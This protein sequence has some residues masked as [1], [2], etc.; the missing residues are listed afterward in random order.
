VA[1]RKSRSS[2]PN[3]GNLG[4]APRLPPAR[5]QDPV[6]NSAQWVRTNLAQVGARWRTA[7]LLRV[8]AVH[9]EAHT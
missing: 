1:Q 6:S 3:S 7:R 4:L 5:D 9:G 2:I 8:T